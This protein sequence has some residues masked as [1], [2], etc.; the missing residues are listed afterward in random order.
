MVRKRQPSQLK[1]LLATILLIHL[2]TVLR[3]YDLDRLPQD[4]VEPDPAQTSL[5]DTFSREMAK[6]NMQVPTEDTDLLN[7]SD[8]NVLS[9]AMQARLVEY[10][11][12]STSSASEFTVVEPIVLLEDDYNKCQF[13]IDNHWFDLSYLQELAPF[14]KGFERTDSSVAIDFTWCKTLNNTGAACEGNYYAGLYN[15]D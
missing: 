14:M 5:I 1:A 9:P 10:Y 11:G 4:S 8:N 13:W 3:A 6:K 12:N 15:I 2:P 7:T